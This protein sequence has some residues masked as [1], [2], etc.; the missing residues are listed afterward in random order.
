MPR[1]NVARLER[2]LSAA[3]RFLEEVRYDIERAAAE[4]EDTPPRMR[5]IH[6]RAGHATPE[7]RTMAI[8]VPETQAGA[9]PEVLSGAIARYA[10]QKRPDALLLALDLVMDTGDGGAGP[11]LVAEARDA[12]GTRLFWMQPYRVDG[13]KVEWREPLESGWRDPGEEE[14]ILDA[15]FRLTA[16]AR[17][18]EEVARKRRPGGTRRRPAPAEEAPFP[19]AAE[20]PPGGGAPME[21]PGRGDPPQE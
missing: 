5:S 16:A 21:A 8:P 3:T 12:G 7:Y 4:G 19:L 13:K 18:A 6:E 20:G 14:M 9:S 1:S 2:T 10:A 15:A 11:V 17:G